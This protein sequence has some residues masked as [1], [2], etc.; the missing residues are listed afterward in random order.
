M[1]K[2][3]E[4]YLHQQM[5]R[6]IFSLSKET[7]RPLTIFNL[8]IEEGLI[9]PEDTNMLIEAFFGM[10][11]HEILAIIREIEQPTHPVIPR[12]QPR[13][14]ITA[15]QLTDKFIYEFC[16]EEIGPN[17]LLPLG[18]KGIGLP[19]DVIKRNIC[20]NRITLDASLSIFACWKDYT[21]RHENNDMRVE[22]IP[23]FTMSGLAKALKD[24]T[25][26]HALLNLTKY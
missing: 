23:P 5:K 24:A 26:T 1:T 25:L 3:D 2:S 17:D 22:A 18:H 13:T 21:H 16:S 15:P 19:R 6:R 11:R 10:K 14:V 9:G 12:S 20:D 4:Y 7:E 8:L